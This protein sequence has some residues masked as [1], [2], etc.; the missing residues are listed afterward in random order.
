[1]ILY[2]SIALHD[3]IQDSKFDL[4]FLIDYSFQASVNSSLMH[5]MSPFCQ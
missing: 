5:G 1:M 3:S 4:P 2:V